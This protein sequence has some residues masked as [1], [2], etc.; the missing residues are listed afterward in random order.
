MSCPEC[1]SGHVSLDEPLG[2]IEQVYGRRT[3]VAKPPSGKQ[4][5]GIVV[6]IAD[7]FGMPF[8]NNQIL[9]D[10]YAAL[11]QYTVYLPD[12]MD[13]K[14]GDGPSFAWLTLSQRRRSS[15]ENDV[16]HRILLRVHMVVEAVSTYQTGVSA[17]SAK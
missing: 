8:V 17:Q 7:A 13:G 6:I 2:N 4:P 5:L 1:F 12:F 11:G 3:Y 10:H 14:N 15:C 9:A 16:Q